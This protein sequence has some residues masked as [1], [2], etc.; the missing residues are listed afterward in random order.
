M[1][2]LI[3]KIVIGIKFRENICTLS[4]SKNLFWY[5]ENSSNELGMKIQNAR[6]HNL[7]KNPCEV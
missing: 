3:I 6:Q 5:N 7:T 2:Q 1:M 4:S